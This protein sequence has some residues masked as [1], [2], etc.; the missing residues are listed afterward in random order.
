M[1]GRTIRPGRETVI[2]HF[3]ACDSHQDMLGVLLEDGV[4]IVDDAVAGATLRWNRLIGG[5]FC[6]LRGVRHFSVVNRCEVLREMNG[7]KYMI[8]LAI[9]K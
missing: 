9:C 1:P 4:I 3:T 2:R 7:R 5:G 8:F 6:R